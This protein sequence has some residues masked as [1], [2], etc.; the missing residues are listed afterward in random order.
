[1]TVESELAAWTATRDPWQQSVIMRVCQHEIFADAE[2]SVIADQL[3]AG[4]APAFI[5]ITAANIPGGTVAADGVKLSALR[6]LAGVNALAEGQGLSFGQRGLT[7]IYGDNA[8]GKS[9]YARLLKAAVGARVTGEVLGNV[10]AAGPPAPMT[11]IVDYRVGAHPKDDEW[12]WPGETNQALQQVHFWDQACGDAYLTTTSEITYRPS[13]LVL[14]DH[15]IA[16]CDAVRAELDARLQVNTLARPDLP[17][18]ATGT[19]AH[20]FVAGLTKN[21]TNAEIDAACVMTDDHAKEL[22]SL[23]TEEARLKA[24]DPAKEQLRL[25]GLTGNLDVLAAHCDR[26]ATAL[27]ADELTKVKSTRERASGLRAA[28]TLAS[29]Q[30]FETEPLAG[31]GSETWRSLWLAAKA[32]SETE[33]YHD[34]GFPVTTEGSRCVLCQQELSAEGDGRLERFQ[35]FMTDTTER[36]AALAEKTLQDTQD[37]A[38]RLGAVPSAVTAAIA[39]IAGGEPDLASLVEEYLT[40]AA[41]V[42]AEAGQFLEYIIDK[43]PTGLA[44]G[45]GAQLRAR[46]TALRS[47]AEAIDA[48]TFQEGLNSLTAQVRGLQSQAALANAKDALKQEVDRLGARAK[49]EAA[50]AETNTAAITQKATALT[51]SQVTEVVRDRFTRETEQLR[52]RRI[53]IDPTAG[54]KGRLKHRPALIGATVKRP[55]TEVFSEGEQTAL[56]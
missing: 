26:L 22:G 28:A 17:A 25:E 56:G 27:S 5:P 18:T 4:T 55:V 37:A 44:S 31:V 47:I 38:K 49:I 53:T 10:F 35:A 24:S 51:K 12:K 1:M 3:L 46:A 54:V 11:A 40:T 33:A 14:L 45:P 36:D 39:Q 32:F 15:L 23:L 16:V 21:T 34:H 48:A 50:Q 43:L 20:A 41:T 13:A 2:V 52:L 30:D 19:E 42:L 7:V 29:T 9:G 6:E 8:S